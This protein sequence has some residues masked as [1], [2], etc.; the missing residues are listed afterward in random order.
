MQPDGAVDVVVG[1]VM[2]DL[3]FTLP[4]GVFRNQSSLNQNKVGSDGGHFE[5]AFCESKDVRLQKR[6]L[7]HTVHTQLLAPTGGEICALIYTWYPLWTQVP[8]WVNVPP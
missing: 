8:W 1:H 2:G 4:R 5:W 6:M 3:R 7:I